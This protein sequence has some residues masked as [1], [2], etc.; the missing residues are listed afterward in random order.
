MPIT[1]ENRIAEERRAQSILL[2]QLRNASGPLRPDDL[3][4]AGVEIT[5][6]I[7]PIV[8]RDALWNLVRADQVEFTAEWA[9]RLKVNGV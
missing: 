5:N 4:A 8:I 9:V 2:S 3:F 1:A 6:P 7:P